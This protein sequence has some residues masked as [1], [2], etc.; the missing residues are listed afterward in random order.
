[1]NFDITHEIVEDKSRFIGYVINEFKD[2]E[3]IK[4]IINIFKKEHKKSRHVCYAYKYIIEGVENKRYSDDGEPSGTAG[5]P[6]LSTID[7]YQ[8]INNILV[9]V[10]RYFGGKK[11]GASKLLRTYRRCA[12]ESIDKLLEKNNERKD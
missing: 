12:K 2:S 5:I 8:D 4:D 3:N 7:N 6:I 1:M 11:L 9:I 10:V